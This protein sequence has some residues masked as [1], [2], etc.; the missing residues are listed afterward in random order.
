MTGGIANSVGEVLDAKKRQRNVRVDLNSLR[1]QI[2][3][4]ADLQVRSVKGIIDMMRD[5]MSNDQIRAALVGKGI[6]VDIIE[7]ALSISAR[8][9]TLVS[10]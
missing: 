10:H 3:Q 7:K 4:I 5:A 9:V 2:P 6:P 1:T 8:A